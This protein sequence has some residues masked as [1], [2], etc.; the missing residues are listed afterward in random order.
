MRCGVDELFLR[1][2]MSTAV[3]SAL[4][5]VRLEMNNTRDISRRRVVKASAAAAVV[6]CFV[7]KHFLSAVRR[8]CSLRR[9]ASATTSSV[10]PSLCYCALIAT[11]DLAIRIPTGPRS[12]GF[13]TSGVTGTAKSHYIGC[14]GANTLR[15]PWD[16]SPPTLQITGTK[17][18]WSHPTS[19]TG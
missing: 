4:K 12:Y 7:I 1:G 16:A 5:S 14:I 13:R 18:I 11:D 10:C 2:V 15:D 19:A 3:A 8:L 9:A 17:C 6:R